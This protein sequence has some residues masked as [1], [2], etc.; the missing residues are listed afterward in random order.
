M[1]KGVKVE[2]GTEEAAI[3]LSV[4][5]KFGYRIREVCEK[6]QQAVKSAIETMT[7]LRVVEVNIFVQSVTFAPTEPTRAEKK[8]EKEREKQLAKELAA[9]EKAKEAEAAKAPEKPAAK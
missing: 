6:V 2:V 9:A 1:T 5:V 4:S 7:G 3:D 8:A